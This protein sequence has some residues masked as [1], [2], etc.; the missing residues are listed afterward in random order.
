M[1]CSTM[2]FF[3]FIVTLSYGLVVLF[4]FLLLVRSYLVQFL[5]IKTLRKVREPD[6]F[7]QRMLSGPAVF[8]SI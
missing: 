5:K 4:C 7:L 8:P 1:F 6:S 2:I 3:P